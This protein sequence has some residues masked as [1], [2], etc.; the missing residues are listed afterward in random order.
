MHFTLNTSQVYNGDGIR[1]GLIFSWGTP[2]R[3]SL[4]GIP[5]WS[6]FPFPS[7]ISLETP[8]GEVTGDSPLSGGAVGFFWLHM[9]IS[10]HLLQMPP[11]HRSAPRGFDF[12]G[13]PWT[14]WAAIPVHVSKK[15]ISWF[16]RVVFQHIL[17]INFWYLPIRSQ[18]ILTCFEELCFWKIR[19]ELI[20]PGSPSTTYFSRLTCNSEFS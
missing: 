8:S 4:L 10:H 17:A 2:Y 12:L 9:H 14:Y 6:L 13:K 20:P 16:Y 11:G 18:H 3:I 1:P 19:R 7:E 5:P 15:Q